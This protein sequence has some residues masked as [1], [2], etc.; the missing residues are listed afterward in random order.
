MEG[1]D[2][3]TGPNVMGESGKP[4]RSDVV[5]DRQTLTHNISDSIGKSDAKADGKSH[6][7][8]LKQRYYKPEGRR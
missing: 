2:K 6:T 4:L 8:D 7:L 5:G 1:T 3:P